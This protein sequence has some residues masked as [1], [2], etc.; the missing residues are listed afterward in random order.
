[1]PLDIIQNESG[2]QALN[3]TGLQCLFEEIYEQVFCC[4]SGRRVLLF[5]VGWSTIKTYQR[6][7]HGRNYDQQPNRLPDQKRL[8]APARLT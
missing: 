2:F 7:S 6:Q 1:L 4:R 3:Y 8:P 5:V